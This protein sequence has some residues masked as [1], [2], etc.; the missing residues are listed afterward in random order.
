MSQ[1]A[2]HMRL[3]VLVN[4]MHTQV[5][6][7]RLFSDL[8]IGE[9]PTAYF[10]HR[11]SLSFDVVARHE[12][13]HRWR[14]QFRFPRLGQSLAVERRSAAR[15]AGEVGTDRAR[16]MPGADPRVFARRGESFHTRTPGAVVCAFDWP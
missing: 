7:Q 2:A 11:T 14:L 6:V 10:V 15:S 3:R 9:L 4:G 13:R 12:R 8:E 1:G 16:Q 5:L